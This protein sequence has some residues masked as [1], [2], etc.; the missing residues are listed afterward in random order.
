MTAPR[1]RS[2]ALASLL[3]LAICVLTPGCAKGP[4]DRLQGT[5]TGDSID[6]IPP[7]QEERATGWVKRTSFEFEGDKVTVSI[8]AEAPR[9]GTYKIERSSGNKLTLVINDGSSEQGDTTSITF[10]GENSFRWDIGNER[11]VK[12]SR[13]T[14]VQ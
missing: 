11:S 14:A 12:F 4:Q 5:W 6:N 10:T 9:T 1:S 13:K 2:L 3:P 8:P 7:E